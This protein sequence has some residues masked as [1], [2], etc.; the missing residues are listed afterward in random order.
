MDFGD[1][2]V[3]ER[4]RRGE[5]QRGSE[6]RRHAAR[7]RRLNAVAIYQQLVDQHG[8]AHSYE[9]VKRYVRAL[10]GGRFRDLLRSAFT[11]HFASYA[12]ERASPRPR[13]V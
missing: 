7:S 5:E 1:V 10:R 2:G 3:A 4:G 9:S 6:Q 12:I 8:Y 11:T 13:R